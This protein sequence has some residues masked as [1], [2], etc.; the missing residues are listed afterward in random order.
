MEKRNGGAESKVKWPVGVG[1]PRTNGLAIHVKNTD[2][3]IGYVD[4]LFAK[5]GAY[6]AVQNKDKTAFIHVKAE[7]ITAAAETL[8][9]DIQEDS[10]INLTN[11]PGKES[12]P[13][14]GG[15][16]A[17]CYRNQPAASQNK[18]SDFLSWITHDGQKY[19]KDRN[20]AP[21]PE[22]IV[23]RV[24]EKLKLTKITGK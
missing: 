15:I 3:A 5:S 4:L 11:K 8:S 16:W 9:A 18:I 10:T 2:G 21:L 13:I 17:V 6:G 24:D 14:S 1:M 20:Y 19:A 23:K 22:G 12:Y 7:N